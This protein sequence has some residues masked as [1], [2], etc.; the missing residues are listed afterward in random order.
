MDQCEVEEQQR[1]DK[2]EAQAEPDNEDMKEQQ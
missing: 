1:S 2:A